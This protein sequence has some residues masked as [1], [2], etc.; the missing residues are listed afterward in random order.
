MAQSYSHLLSPG[1]IGSMM[2][3][4]R[5][6]MTAMGTYMAEDRRYGHRPAARLLRRTRQ[7]RGGPDQYGVG[8]G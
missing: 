7:G 6:F 2:L 5:I 4:N 1:R 3:R 8:V